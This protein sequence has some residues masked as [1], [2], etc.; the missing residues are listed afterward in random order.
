MKDNLGDLYTSP[1]VLPS[2][3][4]DVELSSAHL[5]LRLIGFEAAQSPASRCRLGNPVA[6]ADSFKLALTHDLHR[7]PDLPVVG[8]FSRAAQ[9]T[10]TQSET[11]LSSFGILN[12]S[13]FHLHL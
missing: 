11:K 7:H 5:D 4:L 8:P 6:A 12:E 9:A 13:L 3:S 2:A 1:P 10:N